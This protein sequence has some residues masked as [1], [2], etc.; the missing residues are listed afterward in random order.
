MS[1]IKLYQQAGEF[2]ARAKAILDEYG[3][4]AMPQE[5]QN[6]V[7]TLFDQIEALTAQAKLQEKADRTGRELGAPATRLGV[8]ATATATETREDEQLQAARRY[9]RHGANALSNAE[10]K[11]LSSGDDDGGGFLVMPQRM[12]AD[13]IKFLDD[14]VF[15]RR[16]ASVETLIGAASLG[17]PQMASDFADADWTTELETGSEDNSKP[18]GERELRPH[19]LAKRIKLSRNLIRNSSQPI[20]NIVRERLGYRFAVTQE[21]AFLTGN[22]DKKPLGLF[23]AS[24]DG[25]P[26]SRDVPTATGTTFNAD[27]LIDLKYSLKAGYQNS[28]TTRWIVS[29]EFVKR[30]RKLTYTGTGEYVWAPGLASGQPSTILDIPFDISEFVPNTFTSGLYV[31][32]LG[33]IRYYRIVDALT[34]QIQTLLELYAES[35]QIGYIGRLETDAAPVLPEA[36]ARLK[37]A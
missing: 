3:E 27:N 24:D 25:I 31:A 28:P 19:P 14:Q 16:Y 7:E 1:A 32:L 22:G 9:L 10:R 37:M 29:R 2:H 36:F 13:L 11:A 23:V 15:I 34:L 20:E 12:S 4:K 18:F 30:V 26:T 21:K 6:E 33:D 5:K 17:L 8:G 35:N